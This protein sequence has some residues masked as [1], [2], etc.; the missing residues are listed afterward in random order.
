MPPAP[1]VGS[2]LYA[3]ASALR[4]LRSGLRYVY[5][6]EDRPVSMSL[7]ISYSNTVV[8]SVANGGGG[9]VE[10]SSNWFKEGVDSTVLTSS[11]GAVQTRQ[12]VAL[13][14]EVPAITL[15]ATE[16]RSP[17]R[18]SDQYTVLER[19]IEGALSDIDRDGKPEAVEIAAYRRVIGNERVTLRH[20]GDY[21]ALRVDFTTLARVQRSGDLSY[22]PTVEIVLTSWYAPGIGIIK[23]RYSVPNGGSEQRVR[24][25]QLISWDGLTEGL[26]FVSPSL[27]KVPLDAS[28]APGAYLQGALSAARSGE[29]AVVLTMAPADFG[30]VGNSGSAL[31]RMDARGRV[32]QS[33]IFQNWNPRYVTLVT[34]GNETAVVQQSP[35]GFGFRLAGFDA[36]LRPY[37]DFLGAAIDLGPTHPNDGYVFV[38]EVASDGLRVWVLFERIQSERLGGRAKLMLQAFDTFARPVSSAHELEAFG[39]N[40]VWWP[41]TTLVAGDGR[42]AVSWSRSRGQ[43][44]VKQLYAVLDSPD[45]APTVFTL[46]DNIAYPH[47]KIN[48]HIAAGGVTLAWAG[49]MDAVNTTGRTERQA[50]GVSLGRDNSVQRSNSGSLDNELLNGTWPKGKSSESG[51]SRL[52][53]DSS[54]LVFVGGISDYEW[55]GQREQSG[56]GQFAILETGTS[57]LSARAASATIRGIPSEFTFTILNSLDTWILLNDRFLMLGRG[58]NGRLVTAIQWLR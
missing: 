4:P 37:T 28:V 48:A 16:L 49:F 36:Q 42:V 23:Q 3:D 41:T 27:A 19:R 17:V 1:V 26:G 46:L 9:V 10:D 47:Q 57:P 21:V 53:G 54:R 7:P 58:E 56:I 14:A 31:I 11:N 33:Q 22:G 34:V 8:Q 45:T 32:T 38:R 50:R 18:A 52:Y 2:V 24:E 40:M 35:T 12:V 15:E 51:H 6:G 13:G 44:D 5:H 25:E 20:G 39:P 43:A 30:P 29:G 55:P